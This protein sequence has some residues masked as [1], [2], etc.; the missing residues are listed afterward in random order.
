MGY[1]PYPALRL[2][3]AYQ[4]TA[5][6]ALTIQLPQSL[7]G[8]IAE[9]A[10]AEGISVE[11]FIATAAAEKMSALLTEDYLRKEGGLGSRAE[12]ERVLKKVPDVAP[13]PYDERP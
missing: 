6:S 4:S 5:M 11:Q 13:E 2:P 8:K 7:H 10:Q 12:F 9:L 1:H 3:E